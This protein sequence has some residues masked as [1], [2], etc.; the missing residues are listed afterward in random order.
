MES[1]WIGHADTGP[2]HRRSY[3]LPTPIA[4]ELKVLAPV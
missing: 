2:R 4:I 1:T 3:C